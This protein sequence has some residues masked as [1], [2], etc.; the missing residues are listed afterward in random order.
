MR[1]ADIHNHGLPAGFIERA[2]EDRGRHGYSVRVTPAG[3]DELV[4]PDWPAQV[5]KDKAPEFI[6]EL[7]RGRAHPKRSDTAYRMGEMAAVGIDVAIESLLPSYMSYGADE[8]QAAWGAR[9]VNDGLAETMRDFPGQVYG[10]AHVPL[11]FPDAAVHELERVVDQHGMR[12]V[13]IGSNVRGENLD[14]PELFPFW[15]AAQSLGVLVFIHPHHRT[16]KDRTQRYN[17]G[18]LIGN[19][20]ETSIA[21]ASL[22]FGGVLEHHPRLNICLAHAGGYAPWIRGRWRHGSE[23]RPET[24]ERGVTGP[25]DDYFARL[26][27]DTVIHDTG[28]LRYLI[29]S[30]GA[31][32]VLLGTDY[33]ADMGDWQQVPV[34]RGLED[35]SDEDKA[36]VLGGNALRLIGQQP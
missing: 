17:L 27:F 4:T 12:A 14:L 11:Q 26:Y 13:Q 28:A 20:L 34:I 18:N 6:E 21:A 33:A 36:K 5:Y 29:T 9:A 10:M 35:I 8:E 7:Q 19:P 2:R 23:V 24:R 25:F 16:A 1:T 22:I 31:D 3:V 32:H 30:V 15:D